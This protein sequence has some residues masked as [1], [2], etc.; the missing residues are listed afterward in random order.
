MSKLDF[1]VAAKQEE[2]RLRRLHPT[3]DDVPGC[4][5]LFDD[6]LSC[7]GRFTKKITRVF[8]AC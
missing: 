7:T 4:L 3:P 2:E 8:K 1:K 5:S 6:Y